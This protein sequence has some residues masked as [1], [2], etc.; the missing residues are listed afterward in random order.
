MS[1]KNRCCCLIALAAVLPVAA[2]AQ[3]GSVPS[4]AQTR[5]LSYT[6]EEEAPPPD[7]K[8]PPKS[9]IDPDTGHRVFRLTDEPGSDSNYFNVNPFTPD[10]KEMMY[11]VNESGSIGVVDLRTLQTRIV[12]QAK[13]AQHHPRAIHV[14]F[15]TPTIFYTLPTETAEASQPGGQPAGRGPSTL[16]AA[17]IDTGEIRKLIDLPP[18]VSIVTISADETLGAGAFIEGE[19]P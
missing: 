12:V 10:G 14:G 13:D 8:N 11:T 6:H 5:G 2:A 4:A 1:P 7:I 18:K 3:D 17:N 15:K 16:W 9:W 19:G